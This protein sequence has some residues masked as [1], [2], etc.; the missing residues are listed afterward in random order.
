MAPRGE[1]FEKGVAHPSVTRAVQLR[2][3]QGVRPP[4]GRCISFRL[5]EDDAVA[6]E[7]IEERVAGVL[8]ADHVDLDLGGVAEV[9]GELQQIEISPEHSHVGVGIRTCPAPR[10]GAE[11]ERQ[12]DILAS[13]ELPAQGF[14]DRI[15][16]L[17]E[18]SLCQLR[19][20]APA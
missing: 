8:Q 19:H 11:E 4:P 15:W 13:T 12:V 20:A 3:E 17:H 7:R 6:E 16:S 18:E 5:V 1:P 9:R 14:D 10:P 2:V